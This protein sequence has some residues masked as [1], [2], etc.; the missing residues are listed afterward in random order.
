MITRI[1]AS[2]TFAVLAPWFARAASAQPP[3][4]VQPSVVEPSVSGRIQ[5]NGLAPAESGVVPTPA[6]PFDFAKSGQTEVAVPSELLSLLQK[7]G[8]PNSLEVLRLL[9]QQQGRVAQLAD[10]ATV[11][12]KIGP[13][14]GCGV[15]VSPEGHI[16]TAAHVAT[17][18]RKSAQIVLHDGR[19]VTATTLGLNRS[20]DAGLLKINSGQNAGE[21]WPH[22]SLGES[23]SLRAGMW[24]IAMG[25]PGGYQRA[26]GSVTRVGRLRAVEPDK[27]VTDCA[28]IGGDSGGPLFDLGGRLIAVHS[29]IGNSVDDN[30]HVPIDHY[31]FAWSR[32]LSGESWGM[33]PGFRPVLGVRGDKDSGVARLL[34]VRKGTAADRA[35]MQKGDIVEQ[36]G[37]VRITDFQSLKDAVNDT[38]PGERVRVW[39]RRGDQIIQHILEIGRD[40]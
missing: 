37:D 4:Y 26:R 1:L 35:G 31:E 10:F 27:I 5:A 11:S 14:Q 13:A 25:H 2:A 28:L 21:P 38:M 3:S 9:E 29:R 19:V 20:V 15:I 22:A 6:S 8:V 16:L 18:P 12:I 30:L 39:V 23:H 34:V 32:M 7:G 36:F 40:G 24:C 33:L 17:R